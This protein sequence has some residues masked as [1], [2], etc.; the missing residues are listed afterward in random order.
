[1]TLL[2]SLALLVS[3][4]LLFLL[5][6]MVGKF[7]LPSLGSTP[8]VWTTTVLFFQVVLLAGYGYAHVTSRLAPRRQAL[9][10]LGLLAVAALVLPIGVPD[11]RPPDDGNPVPWLLGVLAVTAGPPF[12]VLA[13]NGPM[14]Q[15][16]L[17]GTRHRAGRDPY[18]LFAASNGGSLIGLLA[19]PLVVERVLTLDGQGEL[20]AAAYGAAALLVLASAV[21]LW[22]AEP[23]AEPAEAA[24][25]DAGGSPPAAASPAAAAAPPATAEAAPDAGGLPPA[26]ASPAAAATP[27]WRRRLTWLALAAVPSSLML[28]TTTYLTRDLSPVPLL[29][30]VPLALYLLT[31]VIAF[32]PGADAAR[33]TVWGRRLLPGIAILVAYTLAI[34]AQQPLFG[35]VALHL[36]GLVVAGLLCHARLA[37]DRPGA[38]R[39]TEYY[40]WVALGGAL[41]GAF[42]A[43]FA[44][45][46]FPGLVEY[47]LALVAACML[48]PA[49]PKKRPDVLEFF[50]RDERPTRYM[51]FAAPVL[52]GAAIAGIL[53]L[54]RE[55]DG[56]VPLE[57]RGAVIGVALGMIVNSAR[58]PIRFALTLGAIILAAQTGATPGQDLLERDRSF[59]GI[60]RVVESEG[61]RVHDLYDGS[62]LH[63]S[64]RVNDRDPLTYY[65]RVGPAGQALA[66]LPRA[67]TRR[68]AAVGL[69]AGALACHA[70]PGDEYT[71]FEIDPVVARIARDPDYFTYLR[72]CG[73]PRVVLGDGRRSLARHRG[74]PFGLIALDAF[75]SDAIPVHL[76][77]REA[78][79]LYLRRLAPRGALMVHLSNRYLDLEPVMGNLARDLGLACRIERHEPTDAQ[80]ERGYTASVWALL[81]RD[82]SHL[83]PL[84]RDPRWHACEDDPGAETWTDDYSNLLGVVDWS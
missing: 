65:S 82:P 41:G 13:A 32:A 44:P 37:A 61:G 20:W 53:L 30:V 3:A 36:I 40:L 26:A 23:A 43:L 72:D 56:S 39:L 70:R 60:Y 76:V 16:W 33:L 47:P 81:V 50:L 45:V 63:G 68:V 77:T 49:P 79:E 6:P 4:A 2:Y 51:D 71:Y 55:D 80:H 21:V 19:Y 9:L 67:A 14:L 52:I 5:E 57:V 66:G 25:P 74:A 22:R 62:T 24:P 10:Q 8:E 11:A 18:F 59:F 75:N 17:A 34:G 54:A 58:R 29:W 84:A 31:L 42:N 38:E 15:R 46:A 48:R 69:G 12:L 78:I 7:M 64:Q 27:S 73:N 1:M 28:G 35:L 83:G